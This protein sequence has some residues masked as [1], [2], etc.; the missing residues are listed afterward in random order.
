MGI[1]NDLQDANILF[2][3]G[4]DY[5]KKALYRKALM[6][7]CRAELIYAKHKEPS[8][9]IARGMA[10][11]CL[12]DLYA[13]ERDFAHSIILEGLDGMCRHEYSGKYY[14]MVRDYEITMS[15]GW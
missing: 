9:H 15:M 4:V 5:Y 1:M 3:A 12:N 8:M 6:S 13:R 10:G 2:G 11:M 14:R 7:F